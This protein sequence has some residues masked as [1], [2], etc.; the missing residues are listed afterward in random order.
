MTKEARHCSAEHRMGVV[1]GLLAAA[2]AERDSRQPDG[3]WSGPGYHLAVLG[4]TR[5][6]WD[7][8][9]PALVEACARGIEAER[10]TL[11][12][13][14]T[15]HWGEP[16]TLD[17]RPYLRPLDIETAAPAPLPFLARLAAEL[18]LWL[19]GGAGRFVALT[20]G[21]ADAESSFE[22]LAAVGELTA[23]EG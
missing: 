19:P 23:L 22:L 10:D 9:G 7:S 8:P 3:G 4:R 14:L 12:A 5:D 18:R 2:Y 13:L 21:R 6:F 20:V 1:R 16:R 15:E 11:A 17:L